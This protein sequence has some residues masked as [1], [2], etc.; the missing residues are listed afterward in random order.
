M[1]P[2][3]CSP[4]TGRSGRR[5]QPPPPL[6]P[7]TATPPPLACLPQS[8]FV[9]GSQPLD[10]GILYSRY[11]D[12]SAVLL[13]GEAPPAAAAAA[14]TDGGKADRKAEKRERR[15]RKRAAEAAAADAPAAAPAAAAEA[16]GAADGAEA[17]QKQRKK[18]RWSE[19]QKAAAKAERQAAAAAKRAAKQ[20]GASAAADG[21]TDAPA[22]P[23]AETAAANGQ[24][25]GAAE[26]QAG[27]K[28][29][30][31]KGARGPL[32]LAPE[33]RVSGPGNAEEAARMRQALGEPLHRSSG[34]TG[35]RAGVWG[36]VG[37]A[38]LASCVG[39]LRRAACAVQ[40]PCRALTPHLPPRRAARRL[41]GA[42]SG[43]TG[44]RRH[45]QAFLCFRLWRQRPCCAGGR[46]SGRSR[47]EGGQQQ[48]R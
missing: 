27:K 48:Q 16:N 15:E 9:G 34:S 32:P 46:C 5:R 3:A 17:G 35:Q 2:R 14:A 45:R 20:G 23:E 42:R 36:G 37:C 18:P 33:E 44:A 10:S 19:E 29:K 41:C 43:G 12:L 8:P 31:G 47:Q 13:E 22:A 30:K 26:V 4:P 28:E 7:P 1:A 6:P 40:L 25:G 11:T 24:D 38:W 39:V 21:A